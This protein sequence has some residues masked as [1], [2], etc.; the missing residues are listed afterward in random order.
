MMGV[1]QLGHVDIRSGVMCVVDFGMVGAFSGSNAGAA[2]ARQ[3][4]QRG[5]YSFVHGDVPAIVVPNLP[6]GRYPVSS[7]RIDDGPFAGLRQAV[8]VDLVPN[9]RAARTIELGKVLVDNA[10][11]GLFDVDSL[12]HWNEDTPVDGMADIVFWGL[13]EKEVAARFRA[14]KLGEDGSGFKNLPVAQAEAIGR[15]LQGLKDSGQFRFAWDFRP[16]THPYYLLAQLRGNKTEA[17]VLD[18]GGASVCGFMTSW[19]DGEFPVLIDLDV[20]NRPIRCGIFFAT[21]AAMSNMRAVNS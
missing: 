18:V 2:T 19:G 4:V 14:P 17:G 12:Q 5:A 20:S 7:V 21:E 6:P 15:D 16:H 3:T 11:I 1:E 10:R 8:M 13:H 9:P